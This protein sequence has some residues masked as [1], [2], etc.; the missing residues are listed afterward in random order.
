MTLFVEKVGGWVGGWIELSLSCGEN[1]W[2][3]GWVDESFLLLS[4]HL[5]ESRAFSSSPA[6]CQA[7]QYS[8]TPQASVVTDQ[9]MG[10]LNL[11]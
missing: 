7:S 11:T 9:A 2:V 8:C 1:G 4:Y 5:R 10:K 3:G 6:F